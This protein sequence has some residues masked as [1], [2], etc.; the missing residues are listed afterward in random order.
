MLDILEGLDS[1][2]WTIFAPND[3]AF[4]LNP[5]LKFLE[6]KALRDMLLYHFS[7]GKKMYKEDLSCTVGENAIKMGNG[8]L[9]E[10]I[11]EDDI[12]VY[13]IGL[14][15]ANGNMLPR[16]IVYD[17]EGMLLFT[18]HTNYAPAN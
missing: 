16:I 8:G 5:D 12:P 3:D 6:G 13:Q 1:D 18:T 14:G 2:E 10:T 4:E 15:N 11:C 9:S 7:L 17:V